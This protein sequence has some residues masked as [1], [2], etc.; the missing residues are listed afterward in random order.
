MS[1]RDSE[2]SGVKMTIEP[3]WIQWSG[4]PRNLHADE[5]AH[6]ASIFRERNSLGPNAPVTFRIPPCVYWS[7]NHLPPNITVEPFEAA[8]IPA[9]LGVG[10][11]MSVTRVMP[12]AVPNAD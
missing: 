2:E 4:G 8:D 11:E 5:I 1:L 12:L 9:E 6:Y 10:W 3:M 7:S